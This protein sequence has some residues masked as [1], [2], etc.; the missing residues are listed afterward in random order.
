M[1]GQI[2]QA[3]KQANANPCA[4]VAPRVEGLRPGLRAQMPV[5]SAADMR[6]ARRPAAGPDRRDRSA[7][8]SVEPHLSPGR[9]GV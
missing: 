8:S 3:A 4:L 1:S 9:P 2:S 6:R 7:A 5:P